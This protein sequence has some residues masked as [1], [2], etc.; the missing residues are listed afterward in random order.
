M[1]DERAA[2]WEDCTAARLFY[3]SAES[4]DIVAGYAAH[5]LADHTP[6]I[7]EQGDIDGK[8]WTFDVGANL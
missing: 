3:T 2:N 5:L 1:T 8:M 7:M 6:S 4:E